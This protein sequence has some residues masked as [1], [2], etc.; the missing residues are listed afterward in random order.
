MIEDFQKETGIQVKYDVFDSNEV[1]ET[2][3]LAGSTG[4][5]IVVPSASFLERQIKAG[6]FQKLDP[7]KLPN[8]KNVDP[9]IAQRIALHDPGNEHS[10]NYLWGTPGSAITKP[11]S[12][13][14][15][16]MPRWTASPCS[17]IQR[18]CRSSRTAALRFWTHPR[19]WSPPC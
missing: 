19:R 9:D 1:L 3:L 8:L 16:P 6:V 18:S 14:P 10:V 15:C 7:S 13:P 12:R 5:D 2:K 4:Y 11:R 17:T